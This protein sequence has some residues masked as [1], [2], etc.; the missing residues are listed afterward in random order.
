MT[1]LGVAEGV[2]R[3]GDYPQ[4]VLCWV[5]DDGYPVNVAAGFTTSTDGIGGRV[6][7]GPVDPA[8][9]PGDGQDVQLIFSHIRPR[10]GVGYDERR[11]INLWGRSHVDERWVNVVVTRASGWDEAEVPFFSYAEQNVSRG[12]EYMRAHGTRPRLPLFWR[13][14]LATR[15]PFLTATLVPVGLAGAAASY[16]GAFSWGWWLLALL[17]AVSAHLGLNVVNDLADES[18]SDA[19]NVTPTPFSGGSRVIQYGLVSRRGMLALAVAFYGLTMAIGLWLTVARSWW[20]LALGIAGV[21]LSVGYSAPPLRLV[22]RGLGEPVVAAGF[23]PLMAGGAYLAVTQEWSWSLVYASLPVG[24]LIALVLYVNQVPDRTA[25][26]AAGKRTLV[27]RWSAQRVVGVYVASVAT[28]FALVLAGP[29]AGVPAPTW[30]ALFGAALAVPV[31]KGLRTSYDAPYGLLGAMAYNI[32]LHV[33]TG[34][35]LVVGY[36]LAAA[37]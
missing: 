36:L 12:L 29:L 26:A 14:F 7:V 37:F 15:L 6:Q 25:D 8:L 11:Y 22:H 20:L 4:A 31:V 16:A 35:L 3:A 28:A 9:V 24:I 34:L 19:V 17:C 13:F 21:V 2:R 30:L 23:G 1:R 18:G 33:V 32:G 10:P 5:G 27:V